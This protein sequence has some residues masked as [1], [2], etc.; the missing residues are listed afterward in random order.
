MTGA[1]TR[2]ERPVRGRFRLAESID[3]G[4]GHRVPG[5]G[6]V[7][8]MAFVA[9]GYEA[10]AAVAVTQPGPDRIVFDV[11][12]DADP[13]RVADQA[14][15]ILS[16]DVDATGYDALVDGDPMLGA[17]RAARPGLRP[18]LFHSAYEALVWGVLSARRPARQ[19]AALRDALAR[20]HGRVFDVAG[21]P[22][23]A[24]P[25][26]SRLRDLDAFPGVPAVKLERM[27]AIAAWADDGRLDTAA[28]RARAPG[29]VAAELRELP[30]IG[31]FYS[32]LVV[33]RALGH[34]DVLPMMEPRVLAA[35]ARLVGRDALDD[36]G[37][38]A[39]A[40]AW[41]PWRT[42][43]AVAIRAGAGRAAG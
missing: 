24:L 42:W 1:V 4:F 11:Q 18:P 2:V 6:D 31:P 14:A 29:E 37:L 13:Q 25:L 38:A 17:L 35:T 39:L 7:M 33:I 43:V 3:F 9:D 28:L 15:R 41:R 40:E 30:G 23:A 22:C 10:Q 26:P 12:G 16:V 32:Q 21:E 8:R 34:T 20:E 27:R 5:A 19:M 36:A